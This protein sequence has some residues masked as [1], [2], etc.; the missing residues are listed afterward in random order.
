MPVVPVVCRYLLSARGPNGEAVELDLDAL[1]RDMGDEEWDEDG[2]AR[3]TSQFEP[4][5]GVVVER[6][7]QVV[8]VRP[9]GVRIRMK[10]NHP[11]S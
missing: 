8:M 3:V 5:P 2:S 7:D 6:I 11:S 9:N 1:M 10:F 4:S